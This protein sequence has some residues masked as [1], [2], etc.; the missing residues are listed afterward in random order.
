MTHLKIRKAKRDLW[1]LIRGD[2]E[3]I[4]QNLT[5]PHAERLR[6]LLGSHPAW[7]R[8]WA[9]LQ[10]D[11]HFLLTLMNMWKEVCFSDE[12]VGVDVNANVKQNA[13]FNP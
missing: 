8:E 6:G 1:N 4:F 11:R 10:Q 5:K 7:K 13:V 3:I 12:N 2:E 9:D